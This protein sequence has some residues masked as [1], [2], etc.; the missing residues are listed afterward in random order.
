MED[1]SRVTCHTKPEG[2]MEQWAK[3]QNLPTADNCGWYHGTWQFLRLLDMVAVP[4]W[5]SDFYAEALGSFLAKKP[6]AHVL[7]S[8]AADY[9]M[10]ATLHSA[11]KATATTPTIV[12]YD[13]C[14]TPL[15][16]CQWYANRYNLSIKTHCENLITGNVVDAPFDLIVT[17]EFLS[18]LKSEYKPLI[19]KRWKE[20]LKPTGAVVTV[21]MIGGVTTPELRQGYERRS[22]H[23]L[24][25]TNG[26]FP[27][28]GNGSKD[29]LMSRFRAF[30]AYHTRHM[31]SNENELR[32][33]FADFDKFS[34][35]RITTPG[36]CVNPTDSFQ[37]VASV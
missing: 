9:G 26:Q 27:L 3:D 4:A 18:V 8:A 14:N 15:K 23:L 11:I 35:K 30:A 20:L 37:I 32:T 33:L 16:S 17:D 6:T 31:I 29:A 1:W 13:I 34:C 12:I 2:G 36:E 10:L 28:N 7:I 24:E 5:H 19:V 21:A 25:R 22:Y